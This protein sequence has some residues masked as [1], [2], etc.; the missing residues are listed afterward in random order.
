MELRRI[1]IQIQIRLQSTIF[2]KRQIL[3]SKLRETH[4]RALIVLLNIGI[5]SRQFDR[6]NH[7]KSSLHQ[8]VQDPLWF[9]N[10]NSLVASGSS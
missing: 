5:S 4:A 7:H 3:S 1:R 10:R 6:L 2:P 8:F 9:G